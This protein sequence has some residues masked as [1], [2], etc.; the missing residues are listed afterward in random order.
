MRKS[1]KIFFCIL[2][3]SNALHSFFNEHKNIYALLGVSIAIPITSVL[4]YKAYL[5]SLKD[6][7][8]ADPEMSDMD[9]QK[10]LMAICLFLNICQMFLI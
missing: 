1:V 9:H 4:V 10:L 2:C 5:H 3:M 7:Y 6:T 8:Y